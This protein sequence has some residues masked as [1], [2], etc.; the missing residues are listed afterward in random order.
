MSR[1]GVIPAEALLDIRQRLDRLAPCYEG[2][3]DPR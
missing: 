2:G 3:A 1:D